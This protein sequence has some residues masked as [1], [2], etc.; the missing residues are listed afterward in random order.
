MVVDSNSGMSFKGMSFKEHV[1]GPAEGDPVGGF[2]CCS[3]C[4][5]VPTAL[6]DAGLVFFPTVH[7]L[8]LPL[9]PHRVNRWW[10]EK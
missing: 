1:R 4:N 10:I 6:T 9:H 8:K 2:R 5:H 3:S 7:L